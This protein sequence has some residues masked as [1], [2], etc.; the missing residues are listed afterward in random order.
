MT[1]RIGDLEDEVHNIEAS[2]ERATTNFFRTITTIDS[3]PSDTLVD[4][5]TA[6]NVTRNWT[7]T[8]STAGTATFRQGSVTLDSDIDSHTT[9]HLAD[10]YGHELLGGTYRRTQSGGVTSGQI[11]YGGEFITPVASMELVV[12]GQTLRI[13]LRI[14][15]D[16]QGRIYTH[17]WDPYPVDVDLAYT[18][19]T[20]LL[21]TSPSPRDS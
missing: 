8:S 19:Y 12:G 7:L 17:L 2:S 5:T 6:G 13:P 10:I 21:Y 3:P 1:T 9:S 14:S 15:H 11:S 18:S 4:Y 20:C 16:G